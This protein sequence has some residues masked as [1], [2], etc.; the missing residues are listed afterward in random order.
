L[1][2]FRF[3]PPVARLYTLLYKIGKKC[4]LGGTSFGLSCRG[5]SWRG[6]MIGCRGVI[7]PSSGTTSC[8]GLFSIQ[9]VVLV[10]LGVVMCSPFVGRS[11]LVVGW[12]TETRGIRVGSIALL[13]KGQFFRVD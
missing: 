7:S 12:T 1:L 13:G 5:S 9:P 3:N 11:R 6:L 10:K 2:R 4:L 8:T